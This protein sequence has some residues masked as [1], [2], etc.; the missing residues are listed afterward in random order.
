M[1]SHVLFDRLSCCFIDSDSINKLKVVMNPGNGGAG[2]YAELISKNMR[3]HCTEIIS[4]E[5]RKSCRHDLQN[6][7]K[8]NPNYFQILSQILSNT[9]CKV[10]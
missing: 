5:V 6:H 7:S 4:K 3:A 10:I 1:E 9:I 2:V 8:Y